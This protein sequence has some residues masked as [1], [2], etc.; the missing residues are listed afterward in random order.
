[1]TT[2][3]R[4]QSRH[5]GVGRNPVGRA[6]AHETGRSPVSPDPTDP[7]HSRESGN[8]LEA[9]VCGSGYEIPAFAGMTG[10]VAPPSAAPARAGFAERP[11][12]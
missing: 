4:P 6:S 10:R 7:R 8:L 11:E 2:A 12:T 9:S 3:T 5:S 1:M